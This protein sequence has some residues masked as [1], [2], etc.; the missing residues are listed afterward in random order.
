MQLE[1]LNIYPNILDSPSP[2][3]P[4]QKASPQVETTVSSKT[5]EMDEAAKILELL[6]K[7]SSSAIGTSHRQ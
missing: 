5:G 3:T 7:A 2:T 4:S 6:L 1:V